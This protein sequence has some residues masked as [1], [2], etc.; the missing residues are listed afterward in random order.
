MLTK[1]QIANILQFIARELSGENENTVSTETTALPSSEAPAPKRRGRP[2][3]NSAPTP[4]TPEP[5]PDPQPEKTPEP[6][7]AEVKPVAGQKTLDELRELIQP[8]IK[9]VRGQEVKAVLNKFKTDD[10]DK[11]AD[12]TLQALSERP[13]TH[14]DFV[15]QIEGLLM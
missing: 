13:E 14:A 7:P 8:L 9:K 10:W 15:S 3:A 6:K 5:A 2:A 11:D 12:Y 4:A 1:S